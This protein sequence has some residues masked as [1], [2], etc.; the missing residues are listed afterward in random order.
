[1]VDILFNPS[2]HL[3]K[4]LSLKTTCDF[5]ASQ[6]LFFCVLYGVISP[7]LSNFYRM[8]IISITHLIYKL[9]STFLNK[10]PYLIISFF[11]T[12]FYC[13]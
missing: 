13:Y 7:I 11:Y 5:F 6:D 1:M 9:I 4:S 2:S 3:V 8:F 12:K 10:L